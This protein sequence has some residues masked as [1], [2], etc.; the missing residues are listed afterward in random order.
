MKQSESLFYLIKSLSKQEKR[1]FTLF[2]NR[3]VIKGGN[4]YLKLFKVMSKQKVYNENGIKKKFKGSPISKRFPVLKNYLHELVLNS[5]HYYHTDKTKEAEI[6][7]SLHLVEILIEKSLFYQAEK[8]LK[9]TKD[10]VYKY[11]KY[12]KIP[13]LIE[14]QKKLIGATAFRGYSAK[15]IKA[16]EKELIASLKELNNIHNYWKQSA[17][18]FLLLNKKGEIRS[19][20]E[21]KNISR[22]AEGTAVPSISASS[23]YYA[24]AYYYHAKEMEY[25]AKGDFQNAYKYC[26]ASIKLMESHPWQIQE[27]KRNYL[28]ISLN[29]LVICNALQYYDELIS[30]LKKIRHFLTIYPLSD[31]HVSLYNTELDMYFNLGKFKEG[32]ALI[33]QIKMLL[34]KKKLIAKKD[35][36]IIL[37]YNMSYFYFAVEDYTQALYWL[38]KLLNDNESMKKEDVYSSAKIVELIIH[39]EKDNEDLIGYR[40]KSTE[41]FLKNKNRLYKLEKLMLNFFTSKISKCI[42]PAMKIAA[43]TKLKNDLE[44][45]HKDPFE[46]AALDYFDFI[47][48]VESK[49]QNRKFTEVMKGKSVDA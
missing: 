12:H 48:W 25:Y 2:S 9:K 34:N 19:K 30:L 32:I 38:N 44:I 23:S 5:L 33:E 29:L 45:L 49:I 35:E 8:V 37:Y 1:Y 14:W 24:K 7:K 15:H 43:F 21:F 42:T 47:R 17:N 27:Y 28:A 16:I 18:V 4:D 22:V 36:M 39:Y 41:R 3:H 13:D 11:E 46:K 6:N 10:I 26:K 31:V 20:E 40:G